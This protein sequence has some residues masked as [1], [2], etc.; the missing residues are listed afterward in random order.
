M[1]VGIGTQFFASLAPGQTQTWFTYGWDINY[2][3]IWSIRPTNSPAQVR[4]E[5]VQ[6][7]YGATGNTYFLT[8]ANTGPRPATFEAKYYFKT[9]IPEGDWCNVG[10]DQFVNDGEI[11]AN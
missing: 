10:P 8:I 3:L 1:S 2:F 4:L 7:A 5:R 11:T 6:I 9:V